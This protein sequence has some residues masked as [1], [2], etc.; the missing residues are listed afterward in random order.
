MLTNLI[1]ARKKIGK[2]QEKVAIECKIS[3]TMYNKIERGKIKNISYPLAVAIGNSV[4]LHPDEI[5]LPS[6]VNDIH[7]TAV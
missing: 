2:S 4:G 1:S 6:E 3:R 7:K 5:F